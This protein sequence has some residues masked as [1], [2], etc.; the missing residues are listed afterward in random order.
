MSVV[1]MRTNIRPVCDTHYSSMS[2]AYLKWRIGT[3]RGITP[4]FACEEIGC[5][6]HYDIINGYFSLCGG[7]IGRQ[8]SVLVLCP[9]DGVPMYLEKF[10]PQRSVRKWMCAQFGC[11]GRKETR[12]GLK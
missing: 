4:V 7:R 12:G 5:Q 2:P 6:R 1:R 10:D 8:M 11:N 9:D 3:D